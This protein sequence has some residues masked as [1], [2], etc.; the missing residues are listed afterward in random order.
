MDLHYKCETW[1]I[2]NYIFVRM[3]LAKQSHEMKIADNVTA[4]WLD[5]TS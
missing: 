3:I 1:I 4:V 2:K 5:A